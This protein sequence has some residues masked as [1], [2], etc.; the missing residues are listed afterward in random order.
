MPRAET[1]PTVP[2]IDATVG[3]TDGNAYLGQLVAQAIFMSPHALDYFEVLSSIGARASH[4]IASLSERSNL[5][6]SSGGRTMHTQNDISMTIY[7]ILDHHPIN[8]F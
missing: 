8:H 3:F 7:L 2:Y 4:R 1:R 6:R 5:V